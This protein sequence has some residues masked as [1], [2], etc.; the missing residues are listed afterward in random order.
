[1]PAVDSA[2]T[3]RHIVAAICFARFILNENTVNIAII[4]NKLIQNIIILSDLI[5]AFTPEA[6]VSYE[7][8][9]GKI[10]NILH[11]GYMLSSDLLYISPVKRLVIGEKT[12]ELIIKRR[13]A[14]AVFFIVEHKRPISMAIIFAK[15]KY[16]ID[17][18]ALYKK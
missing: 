1:M 5:F 11:S 13:Y 8:V 4:A 6:A 15:K 17:I 12:N 2:N 3:I 18:F 7:S 14:A 10:S 16:K 9:F